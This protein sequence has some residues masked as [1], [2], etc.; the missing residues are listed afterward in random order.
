MIQTCQTCGKHNRIG[1]VHLATPARCGACKT[2][3]GPIA[4]PVDVDAPGVR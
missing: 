3:L 4:H 1:A 2:P